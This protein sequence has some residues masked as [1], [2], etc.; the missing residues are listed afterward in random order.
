MVNIIFITHVIGIQL[1]LAASHTGTFVTAQ[2][3]NDPSHH[4]HDDDHIR[5]V[6]ETETNRGL[7]R[8]SFSSIRKVNH[9]GTRRPTSDELKTS[10]RVVAQYMSNVDGRRDQAVTVEVQTYFHIITDGAIG[11][12]SDTVL[13]Q[14]L[15]VLNDAYLPHGFTFRLMNTTRTSNAGWYGAGI[16]STAQLNMKKVLRVGGPST[17]NIYFKNIG[18]DLLG[19]ATLPPDYSFLPDD[20]GVVVLSS[21]VPG[22]SEE[23]YNQGKTL[24]HE[25]GHWLGLYHTFEIDDGFFP[26]INSFLALIGLR[27]GCN[28]NGDEVRDTPAQRSETNGCPSKR[29]SCPFKA[30]LDPINNYMDYSDDVCLLEFTPGQSDR[31][32]A[33]WDEY[34]K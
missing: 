16:S 12:I 7:L 1:F 21:S 25:T 24:V 9:C 33:M 23:S 20:D 29:D 3:A 17:L 34:R 27:T 14:Q 22:G 2:A 19:Y 15:Q 18:D 28:G 30:G 10:S 5:L 8:N 4:N 31:M 6:L 13:Q 11:D 26:I 32:A